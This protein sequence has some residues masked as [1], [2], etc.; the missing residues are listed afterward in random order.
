[1]EMFVTDQQ[2]VG[3]VSFFIKTLFFIL[4]SL[5]VVSLIRQFY[6]E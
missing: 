4:S 6:H 1:M 5:V 2:T 3:T